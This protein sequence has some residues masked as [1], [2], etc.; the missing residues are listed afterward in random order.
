M[1]DAA[2]EAAGDKEQRVRRLPS[3]MV[4]YP[5]LAGV[6]FADQGWKQVYA[7][8]VSGLAAQ[9]VKSPSASA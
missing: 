4:I 2:L 6:L 5:L 9:P 3:Q 7:R 8:L 1:V